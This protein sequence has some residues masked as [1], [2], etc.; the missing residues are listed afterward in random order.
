MSVAV[1]TN[2]MFRVGVGY[3]AWCELPQNLMVWMTYVRSYVPHSGAN[4]HF[5]ITLVYFL[6]T[7]VRASPRSF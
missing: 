2:Q 1:M 4:L 5:L 7:L 6:I 3:A